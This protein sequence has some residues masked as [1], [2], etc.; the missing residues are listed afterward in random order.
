MGI[1]GGGGLDTAAESAKSFRRCTFYCLDNVAAPFIPTGGDGI[2]GFAEK[3]CGQMGCLHSLSD[4]VG[5]V[6]QTAEHIAV[7]TQRSTGIQTDTGTAQTVAAKLHRTLGAYDVAAVVRHTAAGILNQ[8]ADDD[9]HTGFA[10]FVGKSGFPFFREFAVAVVAGDKGGSKAEIR[11]RFPDGPGGLTD[12][13]Y[14]VGGTGFV[15]L[16]TLNVYHLYPTAVLFQEF[17]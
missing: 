13:L 9:V 11:R 12:F 16:G 17:L 5:S 15:A 8:G 6:E 4:G 1:N 7:L 2:S 10:V 14:R 3:V